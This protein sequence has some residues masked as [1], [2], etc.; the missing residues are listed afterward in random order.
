MNRAYRRSLLGEIYL[1]IV[2][3]LFL[4]MLLKAT[5]G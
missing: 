1:C 2:A 3:G 4:A 5:G